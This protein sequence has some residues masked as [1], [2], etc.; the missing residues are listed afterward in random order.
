[1]YHVSCIYFVFRWIAGYWNFLLIFFSLFDK[2]SGC[3]WANIIIIMKY[4]V[5]VCNS[6]DRFSS[7]FCLI[8]HSCDTPENIYCV[9]NVYTKKKKSYSINNKFAYISFSRFSNSLIA[10]S[11]NGGKM[12]CL[13]VFT[14]AQ[15]T[16]HQ[17]MTSLSF[18]YY[19]CIRIIY[20]S[21]M[22]IFLLFS[23]IVQLSRILFEYRC[24][25]LHKPIENPCRHAVLMAGRILGFV[26]DR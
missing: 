23:P 21:Y 14:R 22:L 2:I 3:Q 6:F 10:L 8:M 11:Q 19:D 15:N 25:F 24:I 9:C 17:I 7:A 4:D 12:S 18:N 13:L 16:T 20:V 26:D 5:R 1:M